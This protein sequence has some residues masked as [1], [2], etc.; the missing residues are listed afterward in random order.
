M[1]Y[2]TESD[3][4]KFIIAFYNKTDGIIIR[5]FTVPVVSASKYLYYQ[6]IYKYV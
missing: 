2:E 4:A 5:D 6:F 3:S 1:N